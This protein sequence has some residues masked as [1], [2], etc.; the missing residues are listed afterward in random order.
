[1]TEIKTIGFPRMHKE[2]SE[3]RDFLP[4][5]VKDLGGFKDIRIMIENDYG[6]G[7]GYGE[8]DYLKLNQNIRFV[9]HDEV[10]NSDAVVVLR[11]PEEEEI[12]LMKSKAI[13]FSMLHYETRES[14]NKLLEEKELI[15]YSMDSLVDDNNMRLLVNYR[16]TSRTAIIVGF[17]ELKKRMTNF[18]SKDRGPINA[19]II[20][21]GSVAQ[22]AAK[23]LEEVSDMEFLDK[24]LE[25]PGVIIRM[26]PR[27]IT[28]DVKQLENILKD[29]DILIDASRRLD[30][31]K[32]IISNY[33][34]GLLPSHSVIVDITADPYNERITPMQVKGIEGIPT[35]TLEKYVIEVNDEIYDAIPKCID[36]TNRRL[37]VSCNAWPGVDA[38]NCMKIY[39]E[40]IL[41]FL[42]ILLS[43]KTEELNIDSDDL[44][45]R[46]LVRAS[47]DYYLKNSNRKVD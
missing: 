33:L 4:K 45:E 12:N 11:A 3:K 47:L 14:R 43:K 29:T 35:G 41:P 7:M 1:M 22:F 46:A 31:S 9:S 10:Y 17:S 8:E 26:I 21:L 15:C 38:K 39:G 24:N 37:V 28:K 23:A 40:Q 42:K 30:A 13:L 32:V 2:Q 20:G 5:L 36:S 6:I 34:V 19:T 18:Y 16:G 27:T 25:V 44:Y